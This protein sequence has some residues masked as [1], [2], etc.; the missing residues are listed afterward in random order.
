MCWSLS[1]GS[2]WG[3]SALK[4]LGV[5]DTFDGQIQRQRD[6]NPGRWGR[7]RIGKSP[8]SPSLGRWVS[9]GGLVKD[10]RPDRTGVSASAALTSSQV[11]PP[12]RGPHLEK[13]RCHSGGGGRSVCAPPGTGKGRPGFTYSGCREPLLCGGLRALGA[14]SR[15]SA[16]RSPSSDASPSSPSSSSAAQSLSGAAGSCCLCGRGMSR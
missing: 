11:M 2:V 5:G 15:L 9:P 10:R 13:R 16:V 8:P 7:E 6:W 14:S 4:P 3:T 1:P 12:V